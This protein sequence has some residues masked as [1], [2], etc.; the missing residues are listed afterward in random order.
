MTWFVWALM[1]ITHGA[2]SRWAQSER[3]YALVSVLADCLL[4]AIAAIT[5]EQLQE[6]RALE[7]L[8]IGLFFIAFGTAGRQLASALLMAPGTRRAG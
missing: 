3:A 6:L 8:R 1:L 2:V 7:V 4:I 5:V